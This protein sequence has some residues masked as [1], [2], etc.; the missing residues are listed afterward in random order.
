MRRMLETLEKE[1][2]SDVAMIYEDESKK[3]VK[4]RRE[5]NG[6]GSNKA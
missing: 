1:L 5:M 2:P 3:S 4:E 6:R